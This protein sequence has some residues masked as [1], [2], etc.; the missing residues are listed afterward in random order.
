[1]IVDHEIGHY[2]QDNLITDKE[3]SDYQKEWEKS[4]AK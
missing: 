3:W 2:I 1:M 4:L